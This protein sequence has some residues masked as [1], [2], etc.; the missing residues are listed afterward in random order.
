M[1]S[2]PVF[3]FLFK[4]LETLARLPL[5][6]WELAGVGIKK[7]MVVD[8]RLFLLVQRIVGCCPKEIG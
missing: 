7:V 6:V 5:L 1:T 2:T 8:R 3:L 4:Q